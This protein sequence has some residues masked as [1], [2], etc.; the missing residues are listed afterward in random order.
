MILSD[1]EIR[2]ALQGRA[3]IIEPA[4]PPEHIGTSAVD[5]RLGGD[6]YQWKIPEPAQGAGLHSSGP[7]YVDPLDPEF[8]FS[9]LASMYLE[10]V[11]P[12]QGGVLLK[13][14]QLL[15]ALT[16][17][18]VEL[19]EFSRLAV[20]VEG[21]SQLAR[22]GLGIHL[23]APTIHSGFR[24]HITLEITNQ[25]AIDIMLRP[26]LKV[27]QLIIEQ[28]FGTPSSEMRGI[29]QDQASPQGQAL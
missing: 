11:S 1:S 19:P 10:P 3:L 22:L 2:A 14:G 26:G 23:T 8:S 21:R 6:F 20:R 13:P 25:G 28:V 15:L 18:K 29:F 12:T 9:K 4:P 7:L 24:G 5:L 27:C 16:Q 17:E